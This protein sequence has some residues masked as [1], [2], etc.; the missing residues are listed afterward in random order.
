M[1]SSLNINQTGLWFK[2]LYS[3]SSCSAMILMIIRILPQVKAYSLQLFILWR[4]TQAYTKT[5][6]FSALFPVCSRPLLNYRLSGASL[7]RQW[8]AAVEQVTVVYICTFF[9]QFIIFIRLNAAAVWIKALK[10]A[11]FDGIDWQEA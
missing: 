10:M 5:D 4:Q 1:E 7:T 6:V 2:L 8:L 11:I 9:K 3:D